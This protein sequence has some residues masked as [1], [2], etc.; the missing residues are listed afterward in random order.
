MTAASTEYGQDLTS[1]EYGLDFILS[2]LEKPAGSKQFPWRIMTYLTQGQVQVSSR[3][4]AISEFK[5]SNLVDC[6]NG[7]TKG[8]SVAKTRT[9]KRLR[10]VGKL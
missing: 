7:T 5:K 9:K 10:L 1:I 8:T 3:E 6:R 2:H 4:E